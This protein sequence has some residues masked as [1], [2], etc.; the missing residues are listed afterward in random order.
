VPPLTL[1]LIPPA[2]AAGTLDLVSINKG[3][4][5]NPLVSATLDVPD[6]WAWV[7][8]WGALADLLQQDGLALDPVRAQYC[9][10]R[11]QQGIEMAKKAPVVLTARI[12]SSVVR[13]NSLAD[14]DKYSP[15]WQLLGG[16][17][18]EVLLAGQNLLAT[19]PVAGSNLYTITLDVVRN[20]PVPSGA[21]D[22][23]QV[24]ADVYDSILDYAQ[25]IALFKEGGGQLALAQPLLE[26]AMSAAGVEVAVQQAS[27]PSRRPILRQQRQDEQAEAR[28]LEPAGAD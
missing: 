1:Q 15:L 23:L 22:V 8:K 3:A 18:L 7:I 16:A 11:W 13:V 20:A 5:V 17:P 27:Q 14:A 12:G 10:A 28:E 21:S 19:A 25:H 6:D 9:E 2:T 26:R 24:G 4:T